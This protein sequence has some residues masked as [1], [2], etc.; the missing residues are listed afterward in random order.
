MSV[1][2]TDRE[3]EFFILKRQLKKLMPAA[4]DLGAQSCE[5]MAIK[6][7]EGL[8]EIYKVRSYEIEV[9][10]DGENSAIVIWP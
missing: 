7:L 8:Q 10:E 9:S 6:I 3:V 5:M 4:F 2:H 1:T